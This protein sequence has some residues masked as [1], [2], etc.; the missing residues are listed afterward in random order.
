[1]SPA[2]KPRS[3]KQKIRSQRRSWLL[4]LI[5]PVAALG[6]WLLFTNPQSQLADQ[7]E[8]EL[9]QAQLQASQYR[10]KLAALQSGKAP[11]ATSLLATARQLDAQLPPTVSAIELVNE[12]TTLAG[13]SGVTLT[14]IAP[15]AEADAA[16]GS[17]TVSSK[18]FQVT[19]NG[20]RQGVITFLTQLQQANPL[21]T[22]SDLSIT[23]AVAGATPSDAPA[24]AAPTPAPGTP[25]APQ[26]DTTATFTLNVWFFPDAILPPPAGTAPGAAPGTTTPGVTTPGTT[27]PGTTTPGVT[28]PGVATPAPVVPGASAPAVPAPQATPAPAGSGSPLTQI[29][30]D[31][32]EALNPSPLATP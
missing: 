14:S 26:G 15:A 6:T 24:P 12:V 7:Q 30:N 11:D 3:H 2:A 10:E 16:P 9:T 25:A 8:Q 27:T 29:P 4:A 21:M 1:M 18:Q 32:P 31:S 20:S 19:A 22:I 28:T 5:L 13:T 17:A 23:F